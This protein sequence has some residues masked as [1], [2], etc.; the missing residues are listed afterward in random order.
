MFG[1]VVEHVT[2]LAERFQVAQPV[3][4]GIVVEVSGRQHDARR[5]GHAIIW[6]DQTVQSSTALIAPCLGIIVPPAPVAEMVDLAPVRPPTGLAVPLGAIEPHHGGQLRPVHRVEP[7][8]VGSDRHG[9][10]LKRRGPDISH[11]LTVL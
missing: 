8:E 7:L 10:E 11:D 5:P 9:S 2:A 1:P 3:I 4:G 6:H